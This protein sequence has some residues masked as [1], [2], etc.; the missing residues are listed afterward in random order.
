MAF[1]ATPGV[2]HPIKTN[3]RKE[4]FFNKSNSISRFHEN[5]NN[6]IL[7]NIPPYLCKNL[8]TK[9]AER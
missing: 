7:I 3:W 4:S 5:G 8:K 6:A 1:Y 9:N 2:G